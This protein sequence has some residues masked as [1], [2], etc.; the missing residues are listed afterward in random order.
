MVR[1]A[2]LASILAV[3]ALSPSFHV[4]SMTSDSVNYLS[5]AENLVRHGSL[6]NFSGYVERIHPA[7]Y[8]VALAPFLAAGL[9]Y[10][11]AAVLLNGLL[12]VLIAVL[13]YAIL[14]Q[15][16][17]R[18]GWMIQGAALLVAFQPSQVL[19]ANI[20]LSETLCSVLAL[21][22]VAVCWKAAE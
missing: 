21:L 22:F 13:A 5:T 20:A 9:D 3:I 19:F 4:M 10:H 1:L 12:L 11:W 18:D 14:R 2:I 17:G 15:V 6:Q 7:G 8:A 16:T